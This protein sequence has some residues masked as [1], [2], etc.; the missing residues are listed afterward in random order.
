MDCV[1]L[2]LPF[3]FP[4]FSL[5]IAGLFLE[6]RYE[7]LFVQVVSNQQRNRTNGLSQLLDYWTNTVDKRP[8]MHVRR[9][10]Q[11]AS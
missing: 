6:T 4:L 10:L 5:T 8:E 9:S 7:Y 11:V 1:P 2:L 3:P